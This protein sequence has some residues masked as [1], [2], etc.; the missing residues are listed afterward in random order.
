M[1]GLLRPGAKAQGFTLI[2]AMVS[3]AILGLLATIA[4][5]N[6][7]E[8][9]RSEELNSAARILAADIRSVQARALSVKN[10]SFCQ[11]ASDAWIACELGSA[12]CKPTST[13]TSLPPDGVGIHLT[14]ATSTYDFYGIYSGPGNDFARTSASQNFFYRKLDLSGAPN[15]TISSLSA[16]LPSST[17]ADVFFQR[18]NGAMRLNACASC[19]EPASLNIVLTHSQSGRTKTVSLNGITG[20]ISIQ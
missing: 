15:V 8:S 10:T 11:N 4:T 3:V 17:S 12:S 7:T 14:E 1:N 9:R 18:Q 19:G 5:T 16:K 20:R 13:C 2:E 6:L